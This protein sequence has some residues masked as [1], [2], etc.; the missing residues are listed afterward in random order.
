[1]PKKARL[2][3]LL[4]AQTPLVF[5]VHVLTV[6]H[7]HLVLPKAIMPSCSALLRSAPLCVGTMISTSI[8]ALHVLVV[9]IL[10]LFPR[11]TVVIRQLALR[12]V[13]AISPRRPLAMLL[14]ASMP[15]VVLVP[16]A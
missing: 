11:A 10:R 2:V 1:M 13:E 5:P 12:L 3:V 7:L 15:H 9:V 6:R 16:V 4:L 14:L 8:T